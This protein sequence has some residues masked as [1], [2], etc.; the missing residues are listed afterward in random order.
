MIDPDASLW[1]WLSHDLRFYRTRAGMS[2][3]QMGRLLGRSLSNISNIEAGRRSITEKDAE[4]LDE[5]FATGGHFS[6][7]LRYARLNH[8]RDWFAAFAGFEAR[9]SVMKI[10]SGQLVPALLQTPD[11][12]RAL[13]AAGREPDVEGAVQAR[14][15]RQQVVTK[16]NPPELWCLLAETALACLVGGADVM[17]GQLARLLEVAE[18]PHVTLRLVPNSADANAGLDGPFKVI[19]VDRGEVGYVDAPHGGRLVVDGDEVRGLVVRFDRVGA[20]AL[21]VESSRV[22]IQKMMEML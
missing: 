19:T 8:S 13:F 5:N 6:R 10:Y 12:A 17:R 14:M 7:L 9:A 20:V 22:K 18:L 2:Q 4:V 21:P 11:Y 1:G 3:A 16:A 15:A